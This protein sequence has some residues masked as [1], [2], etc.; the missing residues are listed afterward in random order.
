MSTRGAGIS[1]PNRFERLSVEVE[2]EFAGEGPRTTFFTDDSQT[3]ISTND[4]PDIPFEASLN[5]YRGCEH[6]CS[7]CYARP[8]HEYLGFNCGVDFESRIVVKTRAPELL[9]QALTSP[10]WQ[11]KALAMSG[12]TDCYQPIERK[13]EITRG[14]LRVLAEFRNPVGVITKNALV[15][16]DLD[17]LTGL[18]ARQ[19]VVVWVS[20]TT[21]DRD[22]AR[23]L[24]PR[25]SMPSARLEALRALSAA[26]VPTAVAVAP[27]IPGLNDHEIPAILQAARAA[28]AARAAFTVLR[29]PHGVKEI[30]SD[31]LTRHF[32]DRAAKVL[33]R[34]RSLRGGSLNDSRFGTRMRGTGIWA[35]QIRRLFEVSAG[36]EGFSRERVPLSTA[37]FR[38]PGGEQMRLL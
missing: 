38:R 10:K 16:R 34:V 19:A 27:V 14:C 36:R 3:I 23:I 11:P 29:L 18:A 4:S 33:E 17:L 30:F 20:I 32:P 2:E 1:P 26:G 37:D 12:V 31:W 35:E 8:Y 25:A 13:L 21:L 7:Y 22:L 15:T 24:E 6:G 28:G 5:P 9:R